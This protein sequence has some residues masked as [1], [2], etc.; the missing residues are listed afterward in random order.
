MT[1]KTKIFALL[2]FRDHG[3]GG[4]LFFQT[5]WQFFSYLRT[6]LWR[7]LGHWGRFSFSHHLSTSVDPDKRIHGMRIT[8]FIKTMVQLSMTSQ[9]FLLWLE[10]S[11]WLMISFSKLSLLLSLETNFLWGEYPT[12]CLCNFLRIEIKLLIWV[13]LCISEL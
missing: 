7:Q 2:C 8:A 1:S 3:Q 13:Y 9:I 4:V 5:N 10:I 6:S 11:W 12:G